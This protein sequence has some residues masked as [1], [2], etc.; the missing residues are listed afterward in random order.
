MIM[1]FFEKIFGTESEKQLKKITPLVDQIHHFEKQ[2]ATFERL[3]IQQ[4][5]QLFKDRLH[6]GATLDSLLPEAFALVSI[7]FQRTMN[8]QLHDVQFIG[9]I[10]IHRGM[11]AEMRTGEGKTFTSVLP[12]YLNALD[13][14]GVHIVAPNDYLAKRDAG[15]V[16]EVYALLGVSVATIVD[17][18]QSF[19]YTEEKQDTPLDQERDAKGSFRV[20]DTFLQPCT[21]KQAYQADIVYG[22][23]NQFG[24]DYLRDHTQRNLHGVV[25]RIDHRHHF[26]IV[27]EIDSILIDEARVPLILS[28]QSNEGQELYQKCARV[29]EV[30]AEGSDYTLDEKMKAVILTDAGI[31]RA[32]QEFGIDNLYTDQGIKMVHHLE[33]ALKAKSLYLRDRDY[34]VKDKQVIIVDPFTGRMQEGRRWSEGLHQAVEAK[35]NVPLGADTKTMASITYQNYFKF[36]TKLA[37]MTGTAMT[38]HEEFYKVYGLPV[39]EIPPHQK[40]ARID[41]GDLIFQTEQGKFSA[42]AQAVK[43]IHETGQPVLIGTV[44]IEKNELLSAYLQAQGI[45]HQVLNAKNH[46]K[47]GEII[48]QAGKKGAVTIATN[49]AGRGVDIKLGGNPASS[50]DEA[51]IRTLGGLYVIGTERHDARRIDNQLRGRS[52]RQGD[53][54]QTQFYVSL[55]DPLMRIFGADHIKSMIGT[56]GI[57]EDQ[58]IQNSLISR[59]LEKAQEK[60]EGLNF[61]ARKHVLAYDDVLSHHRDT[62]YARRWGL[63]RGD[64]LVLQQWYQEIQDIFPEQKDIFDQLQQ[65]L[66]SALLMDVVRN[67]TLS[68]MDKLWMEHLEVMD[69][70]RQSVNLRAYGQRDPIVEY[71][72]EGLR[73]F[74]EMEYA[75]KHQTGTIMIHLDTDALLARVS[76]PSQNSENTLSDDTHAHDQAEYVT[77]RMGAA[78]KKVKAK[79]AQT[80]VQAGWEIIHE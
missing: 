49:M 29:A 43:R 11:I 59:A 51:E 57:A 3:D 80:Y 47:E 32:E 33:A 35:E 31:A 8:I 58:P 69:F 41:H 13:G 19:L 21:R 56:L 5:T 16:G 62:V 44:A 15:W 27:D 65:K 2:Y 61:D 40:L 75:T 12:A 6:Q 25:Q 67:V 55:E 71:K 26:A 4:Q 22:T 73:L 48:A 23:N 10:V 76:A 38:S 68:V 63:L 66:G 50:E 30:L 70:T 20:F 28:T 17:G 37:G 24:F 52:G 60:I 54:G 53:P 14:K 78:I 79:K 74:R 36:Y 34:V 64:V 39:I 72:K 77:L 1:N 42:I 45:P 18:M 7:A 9:G 46:E